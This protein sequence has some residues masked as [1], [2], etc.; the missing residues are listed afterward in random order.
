MEE[1]KS[2]AVAGHRRVLE[3][4]TEI[5]S[6]KSATEYSEHGEQYLDSDMYAPDMLDE[7]GKRGLFVD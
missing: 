1:A 7:S 5:C 2:I 3:D 6:S 4:G